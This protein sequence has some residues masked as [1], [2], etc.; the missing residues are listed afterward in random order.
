MTAL[1]PSAARDT[2][3]PVG[4]L[5]LGL[6]SVLGIVGGVFAVQ[7]IPRLAWMSQCSAAGGTVVSQAG[8]N[9]P[10]LAHGSIISYTCEGPTRPVSPHP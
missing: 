4:P 5:I 10:Y 9:E 1:H 3:Q 7:S 2:R 6:V 8:G